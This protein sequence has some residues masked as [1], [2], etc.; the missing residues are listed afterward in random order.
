MT[1]RLPSKTRLQLDKLND[2]WACPI[3]QRTTHRRLHWNSDGTRLCRF[4]WDL[5]FEGRS[6][7]PIHQMGARQPIVGYTGYSDWMRSHLS[8]SL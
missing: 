8:R 5:D 1:H 7:G 3:L 6:F 4:L 2:S